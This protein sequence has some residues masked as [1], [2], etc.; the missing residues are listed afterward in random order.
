MSWS[1]L[2][3]SA[4]LRTKRGGF[5]LGGGLGRLG[6]SGLILRGGRGWLLSVLLCV[7]AETE[8]EA[9]NSK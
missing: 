1:L 7:M 2:S 3:D 9:K 5:G 4:D 8:L 6:E